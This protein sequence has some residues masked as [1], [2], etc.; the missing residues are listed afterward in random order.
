[1]LLEKELVVAPEFF[2]ELAEGDGRVGAVDVRLKRGGCHNE[3]TRHRYEVVLH[4]APTTV[5][6]VA[7]LPRHD[8]TPEFDLAEVHS[9]VR[10]SG[11]PNARLVGEVAAERRLDGL[12]AEDLGSGVDP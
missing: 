1:V 10:I 7:E 8:W 6:D 11:V 2:T 4:K 3:L 5:V 9:P 12:A